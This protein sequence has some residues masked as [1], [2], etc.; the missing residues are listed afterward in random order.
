MSDLN[1]A[2]FKALTSPAASAAQ[3]Q[4][5][6]PQAASAEQQIPTSAGQQAA[7]APPA[8][9]VD[10]GEMAQGRS[11]AASPS[12]SATQPNV[13]ESLSAIT[14]G[15]LKGEDDFKSFWQQQQEAAGELQKMRAAVNA[16][17]KFDPLAERVNTMLSEGKGFSDIRKL[18]DYQEMNIEGMSKL[19]A[20][21]LDAR[22][23]FPT[24][25]EDAISDYLENQFGIKPDIEGKDEW[26]IEVAYK[27]AVKN[28]TD[29]KSQF[30][31]QP[32]AR[33]TPEQIQAKEREVLDSVQPVLGKLET[34]NFGFEVSD[35][36]YD[37]TYK[38]PPATMDFVRSQVAAFAAANPGQDQATLL[39]LGRRYAIAADPDA[40]A[41]NMVEDAIASTRQAILQ[42][43]AGSMPERRSPVAGNQKPAPQTRTA[44]LVQKSGG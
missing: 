1:F 19:D 23:Q 44:G 36:K 11:L 40:F 13:W 42:Q 12:E 29:L 15:S 38:L 37:F 31:V 27:N 34:L 39:E 6:P 20:I 14:G 9:A 10:A 18:L 16:M 25:S 43:Y 26:R 8:T 17:P 41:K 30:T 21:R 7:T 24:L 5:A 35:G 4:P 33:M 22:N 32:A 3:Q 28:L 2:E